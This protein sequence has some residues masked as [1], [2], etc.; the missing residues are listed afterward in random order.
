[1]RGKND[2]ENNEGRKETNNTNIHITIIS[3]TSNKTQIN[4]ITIN[5]CVSSEGNPKTIKTL[6]FSS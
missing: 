5:F 4:G 6:F 3:S 2:N 1:M